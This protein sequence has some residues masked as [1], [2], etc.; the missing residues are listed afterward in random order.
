MKKPNDPTEIIYFII[1]LFAAAS[2]GLYEY[3]TNPF[4]SYVKIAFS[5]FVSILCMWFIRCTITDYKVKLKLAKRCTKKDIAFIDFIGL[6][7]RQGSHT[8]HSAFMLLNFNGQ[9]QKFSNITDDIRIA[10]S[11]ETDFPIYFNPLDITE[12]VYDNTEK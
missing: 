10:Y 11:K 9:Q 7:L 8:H 2:T 6:E 3:I 5:I 12:F 1:G 4:M